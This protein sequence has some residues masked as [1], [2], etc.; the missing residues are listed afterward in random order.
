MPGFCNEVNIIE[1]SFLLEIELEAQCMP[2]QYYNKL[3][4]GEDE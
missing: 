4:F 1:M 3:F 2:D